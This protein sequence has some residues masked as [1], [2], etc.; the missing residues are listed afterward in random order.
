MHDLLRAT[1]GDPTIEEPPEL[2]FDESEMRET[3]ALLKS[4]R[5]SSPLVAFAIGGRSNILSS[6]RESVFKNGRSL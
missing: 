1:L 4:K 2:F 6:W 3:S 5:L